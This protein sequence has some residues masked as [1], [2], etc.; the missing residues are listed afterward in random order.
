LA[1]L[2]WELEREL[3]RARGEPP[4][5]PPRPPPVERKPESWD[6]GGV[7]LVMFDPEE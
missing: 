1:A 7:Q 5:E 3:A 2:A 4:P 6:G